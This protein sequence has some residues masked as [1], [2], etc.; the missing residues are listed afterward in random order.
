MRQSN[1]L[2]SMTSWLKIAPH[3]TSPAVHERATRNHEKHEAPPI[4]RR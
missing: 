1:V 2:I 3:P 4:S